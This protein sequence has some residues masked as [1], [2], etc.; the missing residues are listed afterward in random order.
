MVLMTIILLFPVTLHSSAET[1]NYSVVVVGGIVI[2][3]LTYYFAA[4]HN[5][6][7]GPAHT[8]EGFSEPKDDSE[9]RE[10]STAKAIVSDKGLN[11]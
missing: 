2:L 3:S 7:E 11:P 9:S 1:M 10:G 8:A 5:W 6:F 4:A